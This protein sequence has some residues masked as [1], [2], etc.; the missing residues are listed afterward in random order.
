MNKNTFNT[1]ICNFEFA[2]LFRMNGWDNFFYDS[3][4]DIENTL[5][6]LTG[7]AQKKQFPIL[8]VV[9][10]TD[11]IPTYTLRKKLEKKIRPNFQ[12]HLLIIIDQ[13]KP[14]NIGNYR[15]MKTANLKN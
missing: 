13:K 11:G 6:S 9:C 3:K 2:E 5:Y 8:M 12:E 15:S 1:Y 7:I 14:G 4:I 10:D